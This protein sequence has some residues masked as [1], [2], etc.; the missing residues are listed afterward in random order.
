MTNKLKS[1][2]QFIAIFVFIATT[3][4]SALAF[5]E[6]NQ[7]PVTADQLIRSDKSL[8]EKNRVLKL[9]SM[10]VR[11]QLSFSKRESRGKPSETTKIQKNMITFVTEHRY[12][13]KNLRD[14]CATNFTGNTKKAT[15]CLKLT[16]DSRT[17]EVI[18]FLDKITPHKNRLA[19]YRG[20]NQISGATKPN[21]TI[22]L[23]S[24]SVPHI[25]KARTTGLLYKSN[26]TGNEYVHTSFELTES[27]CANK[28]GYQIAYI[29]KRRGQLSEPRFTPIK[30]QLISDRSVLT[31]I[32]SL[33]AGDTDS[34]QN[35]SPAIMKVY[36][37]SYREYLA[38]YSP[39]TARSLQEWFIVIPSNEEFKKVASIDARSVN[40]FILNG[41]PYFHFN[42]L[43]NTTGYLADIIVTYGDFFGKKKVKTVLT[44]S[45]FA[46]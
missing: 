2:A 4:V 25:C 17:E 23:L 38:Q 43:L 44:N 21:T 24:G 37:I 19:L 10:S 28:T 20:Q 40:I 3:F 34:A 11:R 15:D 16:L 22:Y 45:D 30:S 18:D 29:E 1:S 32:D 12:W 39:K 14:K 35:K 27:G 41:R 36:R 7:K 5:A 8:T 13:Q 9:I 46:T 6:I 42:G 26:P 33:V 31:S